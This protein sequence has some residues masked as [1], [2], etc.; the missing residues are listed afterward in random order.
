MS[1]TNS[2]PADELANAREIRDALAR[3]LADALERAQRAEEVV[4]AVQA[5]RHQGPGGGHLAARHRALFAA[6]DKYERQ[7]A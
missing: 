4:K 1:P 2:Y 5:Y 6:V 7:S 3:Q